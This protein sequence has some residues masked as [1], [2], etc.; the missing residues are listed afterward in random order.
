[1]KV[2]LLGGT[3]DPPH[4]GHLIL[5]EIGREQLRLEKVLFMPAGD[6]WR[7]ANRGVTPA[8]HRVAMTRLC[9]AGNAAFAV[10]EREVR[11]KGPTY[12]VETLRELRD[13]CPEDAL[14]FLAGQD[15]L[16]DMPVWR[17]PAEI[18]RLAQIAIAPRRDAPLPSGLPFD[19]EGLLRVD[20]PVIDI[21]STELRERARRGSSLRYLVPDAVQAYIR[22][23][24]LYSSS[25]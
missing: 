16:A 22:E 23:H 3:F 20:M 5:A 24:G 17:E 9:I 18:A 2:G 21:S 8:L 13:E 7:K 11:R 1:V 19:A 12:T 25:R 14:Y 4:L 6:P 10:D 15:A